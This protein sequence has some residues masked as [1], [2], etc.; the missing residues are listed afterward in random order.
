[1]SLIYNFPLQYYVLFVTPLLEPTDFACSLCETETNFGLD[2]LKN[3]IQLWARFYLQFIFIGSV[4]SKVM[5]TVQLQMVALTDREWRHSMNTVC[6]QNYRFRIT[7]QEVSILKSKPTI[8]FAFALVTIP[9]NCPLLWS[10][11]VSSPP[12]I[13]LLA[14]NTLGTVRRPVNSVR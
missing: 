14:T 6:T 1:M 4:Q 7:K 12:P 2:V 9:A 13:L 10:A 8:Y 5:N 11:A 3:T